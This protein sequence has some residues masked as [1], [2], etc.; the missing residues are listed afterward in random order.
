MKCVRVCDVFGKKLCV[1]NAEWEDI[2]LGHV[3]LQL[4]RMQWTTV[5]GHVALSSTTTT[6]FHQNYFASDFPV[7]YTLCTHS[8]HKTAHSQ[9]TGISGAPCQTMRRP[10]TFI[11][12]SSRF[13]PIDKPRTTTTTNSVYRFEAARG[14]RRIERDRCGKRERIT[15]AHT[16][17]RSKCI[18]KSTEH[19]RI[20]VAAYN[21]TGVECGYCL[22][23]L[24]L[25]LQLTLL[26]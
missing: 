24:L 3:P 8:T 26:I 14:N 5:S 25:L 11:I 19:E 21:A 6:I 15:H 13:W 1:C 10:A 20:R 22:L 4:H 9:N 18:Q 2:P 7:D 23:S 17:T 16:H 12:H